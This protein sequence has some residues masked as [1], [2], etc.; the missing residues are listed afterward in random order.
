MDK[1]GKRQ[2]LAI[3]LLI[4]FICE[5][6]HRIRT[7]QIIIVAVRPI[8]RI[9]VELPFTHARRFAECRLQG[10]RS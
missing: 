8:F 4:L 9:M 3:I 1:M 6:H 2:S 5:S 10:K 7:A